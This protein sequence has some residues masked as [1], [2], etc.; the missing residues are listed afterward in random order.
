MPPSQSRELLSPAPR[1]SKMAATIMSLRYRGSAPLGE[2]PAE[3]E[4]QEGTSVEQRLR[5]LAL[6]DLES[7]FIMLYAQETEHVLCR[8]DWNPSGQLTVR[9]DFSRG[10]QPYR[11]QVGEGQKGLYA[12]WLEWCRPTEDGRQAPSGPRPQLV[13]A[14][15]FERDNLFIHYFMELPR[16][17]RASADTRLGGVTQLC[18]A[19]A[20]GDCHFGFPINAELMLG[21]PDEE[22]ADG[23]HRWP[24]LYVE[25]LSE[26]MLGVCRTE[27]YCHLSVPPTA[28]A[29]ERRLAAWRPTGDRT[30]QLRRFFIGGSPELEDP[31]F[32]AV[33]AGLSG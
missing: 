7:M 16:G 27:G 20:A 32:V 15:G 23:W 18:R 21:A 31:S 6:T 33:P 11:Y 24:T 4:H 9:P 8:L 30:A 25:V 29:L 2:E 3:E 26:D 22:Q 14:R 17:W 5:R 12:Y 19:S 13:S 10:A 1:P 28:G